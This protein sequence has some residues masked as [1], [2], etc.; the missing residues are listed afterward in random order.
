MTD[1]G[2]HNGRHARVIVVENDNVFREALMTVLAVEPGFSCLGGFASF[3]AS[4][5]F[6]QSDKPDVLLLD[7]V[8]SRKSGLDGI[9]TLLD[10]A[11]GM[12]IIVISIKND[13]ETL[14]KALELGA[15]GYLVKPVGVVDVLQAIREVRDGGSPMSPGLARRLVEFMRRNAGDQLHLDQLSGRERE[16]LVLLAEGHSNKK[17]G[18]TLSISDRTVGAHV[19]HIYKKLDVKT[20]ASAVSKYLRVG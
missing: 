3:E 8:L 20:R 19:Q 15:S 14:F 13:S 10:A 16:I 5:P 17:I 7:L 4:I 2:H 1:S 9:R 12:E 18:E 6:V 11:P